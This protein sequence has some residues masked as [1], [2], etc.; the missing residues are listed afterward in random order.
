[1]DVSGSVNA[2]VDA[3]VSVPF[4][5]L[6]TLSGS[7]GSVAVLDQFVDQTTSRL[8]MALLHCS[9]FAGILAKHGFSKAMPVGAMCAANAISGL[10][11]PSA[12]CVEAVTKQFFYERGR[13]MLPFAKQL[14]NQEMPSLA[15]MESTGR[16]TLDG[17]EEL[18]IR[19][20]SDSF[21]F[22][23][24]TRDLDN[25]YYGLEKEPAFLWEEEHN[26]LTFL[27]V[28]KEKATRKRLKTIFKTYFRSAAE[29]WQREIMESC[30]ILKNRVANIVSSN[31][32]NCLWFLRYFFKKT[33]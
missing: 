14:L 10:I 6:V 30:P 25:I 26:S 20:C 16:S 4:G 1:M 33:S 24:H 13:C 21:V 27:T 11:L 28:T 12:G 19:S 9:L 18:G 17:Q 31:L 32:Q 5:N 23:N 3:S 29:E 22:Q 15:R 7:L 2:V 8:T